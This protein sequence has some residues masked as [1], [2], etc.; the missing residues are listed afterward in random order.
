LTAE[1]Q[2][3]LERRKQEEQYLM[4]RQKEHLMH[5]QMAQ[6]MQYQNQFGLHP[7]QLQHQPSTQ[8]LHSHPSLSNIAS[9]STYQPS[10]AQGSGQ[11]NLPGFFDNSLGQGRSGFGS[12]KSGVGNLG[13]IGELDDSSMMD[14]L[15]LENQKQALFGAPGQRVQHDSN[16]HAQQVNSML[17][18][19]AQLE[20]EQ[21][22]YDAQQQDDS[23]H[24]MLNERLREFKELQNQESEHDS[25]L[26][27]VARDARRAQSK[28]V[29]QAVQQIHQQEPQSLKEQVEQAVSAQQS[30]AVQSPWAKIDTSLPHPFPPAP[31]QSPLPAPAAQRNRSNVADALHHESRS[32]S[33]TPSLDT[34]SASIAPWASQTTEASRGPSLKEIQEAEAK[35]AAKAEAIA[36]EARRVQ[37]EKEALTLAQQPI[38]PAPGLPA[39]SNWASA[40]MAS[41]VATPSAAWGAKATPAPTPS[42][43]A[44]SMAQIQKE[45]E[46]RKKRQNA[47]ALAAQQAA[48]GTTAT[49]I[50]GKRYAEL[51]SKVASAASSPTLPAVGGAWTTVTAG[52]KAKTPAN[53]PAAAPA[54]APAARTVSATIAP[55]AVPAAKKPAPIR[56]A[57]SSAPTSASAMEGFKSWAS[58]ELRH[59]VKPGVQTEDFVNNLMAF[60]QEVEIISEAIHSVTTTIDSRHLAEEFLRRKKLAE[61]GV[62]DAALVGKSASPASVDPTRGAGGWSE[63]AKKSKEVPVK[64]DVSSGLFKVVAAKKKGGKR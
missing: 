27:L 16:N 55:A 24:P 36:A 5:Q 31:S 63:V 1:Q 39:T 53:T 34:P 35:N 49:Q 28:A 48:V 41:P 11:S 12:M 59:D 47:A 10:P 33:Q 13:N 60:P 32:R 20:R 56:T 21:A 17:E 37:L 6:R 29:A 45:E 4:A 44:K 8:S 46:A 30:P 40:N 3:A 42:A 7:H 61:K 23:D 22:Q 52:G 62:F 58:N 51:A 38:Q 19:R 2:N 50:A 43:A 9:P 14:S 18:D 64:E 57:T 26:D 25:A 15:S 54:P